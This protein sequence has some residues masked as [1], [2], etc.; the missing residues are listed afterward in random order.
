MRK[1]RILLASVVLCSTLHSAA[2]FYSVRTNLVG[3][4]T[5]NL[6]IEA[7]MTLN[8]NW[9]LH[10]PVQYN[11]FVFKDNR[12]FRNFYIA[13]GVRYWFLESYNSTFVGA[14]I[15]AAE[16]GIGNLFGNKYRYE[17]S[18]IGAGISIGHAYTLG[19]KWNIE[20]EIGVGA[21]WLDYDKYQCKRC[22]DLVEHKREWR[23]LPT[24][25]AINLVYL[26]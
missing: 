19:K 18:G 3:L 13:P 9:S 21:I 7:S 25:T 8:R 16:Y 12:Q 24:R 5:T 26:F 2:Q 15:A 4:A 23:V 22:G 17:G 20:W 11:P 6:N 1:K 10:V 14:H